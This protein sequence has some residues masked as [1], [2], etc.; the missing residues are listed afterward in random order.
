MVTSREFEGTETK[1]AWKKKKKKRAVSVAKFA[2]SIDSELKIS[3][4]LL[5]IWQLGII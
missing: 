3:Q 2:D 4:N 5:Y 1:V